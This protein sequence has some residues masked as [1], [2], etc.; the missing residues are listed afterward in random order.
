MMV[1]RLPQTESVGQLLKALDQATTKLNQMGQIP[2]DFS[3]K[4]AKE[5]IKVLQNVNTTIDPNILTGKTLIPEGM[6][7]SIEKALKAVQ[8]FEMNQPQANRGVQKNVEQAVTSLSSILSKEIKDF[9]KNVRNL[10]KYKIGR[11]IEK[12]TEIDKSKKDREG[13]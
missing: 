2:N 9:D 1:D 8:L 5:L 13:G 7:T 10:K 12:V 4:E 11:K 3:P 6:S